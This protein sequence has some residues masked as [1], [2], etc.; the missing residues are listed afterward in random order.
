M[1]LTPVVPLLE[2]PP[3][4]VLP[5]AVNVTLLNDPGV[6]VSVT[7]APVTALGPLLLTTMVYV[8][9]PPGATVVTPSFLLM[10]RSACGV[11]CV[12]TG[13]LLLAP[14]SSA[15]VGVSVAVL[16]SVPV[17]VGEIVPLTV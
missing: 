14:L 17:A 5:A 16:F 1:L 11:R 7:V 6:N 9:V 3:V 15:L 12:V 4:P 2:K 13:E 10:L 8:R